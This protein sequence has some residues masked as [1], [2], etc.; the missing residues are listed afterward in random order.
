MK[1]VLVSGA[2]GFVGRHVVDRLLKDGVAVRVL[3]RSGSARL[4]WGRAVDGVEGDVRDLRAMRIAAADCDAVFHLASRVHRLSEVRDEEQDHWSVNVEGTR[5]V[6]EG[7]LAGGCRQ[8]IFFSTVKVMGEETA[9]CLDESSAPHPVGA[10]GRT[11]LEAERLVLD[12]GKRVGLHAVCLRLPLVYG[13]GTKGNLFRMISAIDHGRFPP[14]KEVNNRRSLVHV[15][16]VVE[17]AMLAASVPAAAGQCYIVTDARPYSTRELYE[18]I[19]LGL[20]KAIPK[21]CVPMWSLRTLGLLGDAVCALTGTRFLFDSD[22]LR[23]L[24]GSA[25]YSST[26]IARELGY[27]PTIDFERALPELIAWYRT[28]NIEGLGQVA[29][30][31]GM[32]KSG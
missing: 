28:T 13:C 29:T 31:E 7:A 25:Q 3:S 18:R 14:L 21:W 15:S 27:Q 17:A 24:T 11:K 23:K 16:N 8:F 12:Y 5:N 4:H 19:V 10:Y 32:Q 26:K 2:T 9:E 6:L 20:G 30:V 1:R 22:A